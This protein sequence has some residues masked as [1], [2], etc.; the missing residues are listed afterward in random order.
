MQANYKAYDFE[1]SRERMDEILDSSDNNYQE[2]NKVP[3][4]DD[5][6]Y[7]NGYHINCSALFISLHK[8]LKNNV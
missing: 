4:I 7:T 6:T 3:S 5:L 1:K 8:T 2:S